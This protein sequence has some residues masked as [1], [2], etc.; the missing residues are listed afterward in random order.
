MGCH[1]KL[2][3]G[4]YRLFA[5]AAADNGGRL[6]ARFIDSD[7]IA[8]QP[9]SIAGLCRLL[10][11]SGVRAHLVH[12][13]TV[14]VY[15][16]L[17]HRCLAVVMALL[18]WVAVFNVCS[19]QRC[20]PDR[21]EWSGTVLLDCSPLLARKLH[22]GRLTRYGTLAVHALRIAEAPRAT[23]MSFT[24][25]NNISATLS[26]STPLLRHLSINGFDPTQ[27][28]V[29]IDDLLQHIRAS[30]TRPL[31][32]L[33]LAGYSSS[34][35]PRVVLPPN[36]LGPDSH[37]AISDVHVVGQGNVDVLRQAKTSVVE[38]IV[39]SRHEVE[40][41]LP[42]PTEDPDP[43]FFHV[44]GPVWWVKLSSWSL[45]TEVVRKVQVSWLAK[46][47]KCVTAQCISSTV[48][49]RTTKAY[50]LE[51]P[52]LELTAMTYQA[53]QSGPSKANDALGVFRFN[54]R[55]LRSA[56]LSK[57]RRLVEDAPF[58]HH[59][60]VLGSSERMVQLCILLT[61]LGDF[62]PE[63]VVG[64]MHAMSLQLPSRT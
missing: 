29:R 51:Y 60:D 37:L 30:M 59:R 50:W 54:A 9:C 26:P 21:G 41:P 18:R 13:A 34:G 16:G 35:Y 64:R 27:G 28:K 11:T 22:F 8:G 24:N 48:A 49:F 12:S 1:S 45:I 53:T 39:A 47:T 7:S 14:V 42:M 5:T 19:D 40:H 15:D 25:I 44:N 62:L 17:P 55:W 31:A 36:L 20:F 56:S 58:R 4:S 38:G 2:Q 52:D 33:N 43:I 46:G 6:V 63:E 32:R 3:T 10:A 57:Y 23:A 61:V